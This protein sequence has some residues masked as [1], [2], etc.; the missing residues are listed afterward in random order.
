MD[1]D[2]AKAVHLV[3][4]NF[5]VMLVNTSSSEEPCTNRDGDEVDDDPGNKDTH[6]LTNFVFGVK[7]DLMGGRVSNRAIRI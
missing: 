5:L 2:L 3:L 1:L 6:V 4:A 7:D